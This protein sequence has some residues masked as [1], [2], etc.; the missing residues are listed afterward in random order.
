MFEKA[1]EKKIERESEPWVDGEIISP[2]IFF[3]LLWK[4]YTP[5]L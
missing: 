5:F 3:F 1:K 2:P 4:F